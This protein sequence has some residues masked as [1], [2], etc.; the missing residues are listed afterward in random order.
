MIRH[1]PP[2]GGR[3][4]ARAPPTARAAAHPFAHA[5]VRVVLPVASAN[6][7]VPAAAWSDEGQVAV[8]AGD[9]IHVLTPRIGFSPEIAGTLVGDDAS[10]GGSAADSARAVLSHLLHYTSVIPLPE[11]TN[12]RP[13]SALA[14]P[15]ASAE[16]WHS[17][18]WSPTGI[19]PR[20]SCLLAAID[21]PRRLFVYAAA[22]DPV[23]GP[24]TSMAQ[25]EAPVRAD[26]PE[27]AR[28]LSEQFDA[29]AWSASAT[30][31]AFL[32][33]GTRGGDLV[34]W[35]AEA[36]L[37]LAAHT[38]LPEG[39]LALRWSPWL[40][41]GAGP[42]SALLAVHTSAGVHVLAASLTG[43]ALTLHGDVP[44][45]TGTWPLPLHS[46]SAL[47]WRGT[48]LY[49]STPGALHRWDL[50]SGAQETQPLGGSSSAAPA[51]GVVVQEAA[52][53]PR[54]VLQDG[55]SY[56]WGDAH[57][58]PPAPD[59]E[60]VWSAAADPCARTAPLLGCVLASADE[61]AAWRYR[62]TRRLAYTLQ[63]ALPALWAPDGAAWPTVLLEHALST[64]R[65]PQG[66]PTPIL[67][68]RPLLLACATCADASA[69]LRQLLPAAQ[70]A[71]ERLAERAQ[72]TC[73]Q[74]ADA[75]AWCRVLEPAQLLAWL[76][77][78]I[79]RHLHNAT[80]GTDAQP[81]VRTAVQEHGAAA[82]AVAD[83]AALLH[84]AAVLGAA[85]R[86]GDA[87]YARLLGAALWLGAQ[88][89]WA[90]L[91]SDKLSAYLRTAAQ[92]LL[93]RHGEEALV[94]AWGQSVEEV[95]L[96]EQC[97]ACGGAIAFRLAPAARCVT[98]HTFE[99]CV[100][101]FSLIDTADTLTCV[102]CARQASRAA[103]DG[104]AALPRREAC[105]RCGNRWV[106]P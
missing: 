95:D 105:I 32:A 61:P 1:A 97:P 48:E 89:D 13:H 65:S 99:R 5:L 101:T 84:R 66:Y 45:H 27:H 71:T 72:A 104:T 86:G 21:A 103:L 38:Q 35:Q 2:H 96:G 54:F 22:R 68:L 41:H 56:A 24:W 18:A 16:H 58:S 53:A 19:G 78:W 83:V 42:Q 88:Q 92:E 55:T 4:H 64:P 39:V 59:A 17:V 62:V 98:G 6:A 67:A 7:G 20:A 91:R 90:S 25:L 43:T 23:R 63:S 9:A 29:A 14:P 102:G 57:P 47:A 73:T 79:K 34:V 31:A 93:T 106:A 46:V 30:K 76:W 74:G 81:D 75:D 70:H 94:R 3:A 100:A 85:Q 11:R 69:F 80:P 87:S 40:T 60:V 10:A 82:R 33:A 52:D 37:T 28:V 51:A 36:A 8:V 50:D 12:L 44:W 49:F 77:A 15:D 26:V